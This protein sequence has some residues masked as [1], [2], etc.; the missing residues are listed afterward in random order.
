MKRKIFSLG[1]FLLPALTF[2]ANVTY[3]APTI[4]YSPVTK[5]VVSVATALAGIWAFRKVI[6]TLNKS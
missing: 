3:N 1:L 6:K 4:D 5:T 2:A